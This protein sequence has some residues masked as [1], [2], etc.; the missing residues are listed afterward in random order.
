MK[1]ANMAYAYELPVAMMNCPGNTMA[2]LA[3]NLP[4]HDDGSCR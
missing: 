4:N 3:T 1:V 2:H